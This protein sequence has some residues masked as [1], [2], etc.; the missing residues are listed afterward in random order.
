MHT[1]AIVQTW[2]WTS[3]VILGLM[4]QR[5]TNLQ[6][7]QALLEIEAKLAALG[8][9]P[10]ARTVVGPSAAQQADLTADAVADC[11]L[12]QHSAD[13]CDVPALAATTPDV[14]TGANSKTDALSFVP[15]DSSLSAAVQQTDLLEPLTPPVTQVPLVIAS[16][17]DGA[18]EE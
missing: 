17:S 1:T 2:Q 16:D 3:S 11:S 9:P 14:T 8:T 12:L 13:H 10:P 4:Q 15:M 18:P 7:N 5:S 6:V